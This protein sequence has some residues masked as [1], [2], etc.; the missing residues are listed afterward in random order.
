[1]R[2]V[3]MPA[4]LAA[5]L[6]LSV[7]PAMADQHIC[8]STRDI[9]SSQEEHDGAALLFKMRD[10]TQ[11]RNTLQSRC[12]DLVWNGY[13]WNLRNPDYTVCENQQSLRVLQSGQVCM[14]GKFEKIAPTPTPAQGHG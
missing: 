1:M 6:F 12:P 9:V 4:L 11:Y 7:A 8:I 5:S 13:V 2:T 10:G 14:L 3:F